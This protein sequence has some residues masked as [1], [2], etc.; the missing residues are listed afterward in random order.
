MRLI[1]FVTFLIVTLNADKNMENILGFYENAKY[2]KVC[3]DG[4]KFFNRG[5]KNEQFLSIVGD[6]CA[7]TDSIYALSQLQNSLIKTEQGRINASYFATLVLQKKLIYQF[8]VDDLDLGYLVLPQTR[9]ILSR[10]FNRIVT[11]KYKILSE[12]PKKIEFTMDNK[13]VIAYSDSK[14]DIKKVVVKI[15]SGNKLVRRHVYW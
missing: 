1:L 14:K 5:Y 4:L 6:A 7:K 2:K 10:L 15:Y 13:K 12:N 9:H 11:K 3:V 8:F